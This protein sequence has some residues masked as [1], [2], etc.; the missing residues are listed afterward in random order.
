M[1]ARL[2]E[3]LEKSGAK[4]PLADSQFDA[5]KQAER[6]GKLKTG[7][8]ANLERRHASYLSEDYRPNPEWWGSA[9]GKKAEK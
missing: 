9:P 4:M 1:R 5:A 8:K 3:W 7:G 2:D 6:W